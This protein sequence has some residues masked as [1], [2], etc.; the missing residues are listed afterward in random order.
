[1]NETQVLLMLQ[2]AGD[3]VKSVEGIMQDLNEQVIDLNRQVNTLS[4][5]CNRLVESL[6]MSRL[7]TYQLRQKYENRTASE[8][9]QE[10]NTAFLKENSWPANLR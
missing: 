1:M 4:D 2:E 9:Y 6:R 7:E 5:N 10:A 3:A 8:L